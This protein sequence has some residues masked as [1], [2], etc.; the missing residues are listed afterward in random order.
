MY[1]IKSITPKFSKSDNKLIW[2]SI[3]VENDKWNY[4]FTDFF[5]IED[6][7]KL[8]KVSNQEQAL[9]LKDKKVNLITKIEIINN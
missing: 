7:E 4:N 5:T 1:Y 3:R 6:M 2:Y 8:Y 9:K